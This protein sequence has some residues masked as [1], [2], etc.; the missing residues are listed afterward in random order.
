LTAHEYVGTLVVND[1]K[2]L[3]RPKIRPENLFLMLEVGLPEA[4]WRREAFDYA[5]T[6]DLLPSV[7][8]FVARTVETTLARGVVGPY[9]ELQERLVAMRGRLDVPDQLSRAGMVVPVSCRYDD[10]TPDIAENR[11]LRAAVR[12]A[13]RVSQVPAVDRRR[14]M[15]HLVTLDE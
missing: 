14:L 8:S 13:L 9:R 5:T 3:I 7:I 1:V 4:A 6:S 12:R 11:Y 15:Q 2:V 10:Y